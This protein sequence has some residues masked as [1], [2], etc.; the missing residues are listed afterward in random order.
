MAESSRRERTH[1][2]LIECALGL[3]ERQGFEQTTVSQI[4]SSAGVT[5]MTFFRH[6]AGKGAV[7]TADPYDPLIVAAIAAEPTDHPPLVRAI[8]GLHEAFG[9]LPD[10]AVE[11]LRRRVKIIAKS[12]T[13]RA[14]TVHH[15]ESTE[16]GVRDQLIADGATPFVA[17]ISAASLMTALTTAL[18]WWAEVGQEPLDV[19]V[20][21]ALDVLG[22]SGG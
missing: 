10:S 5:E 1:G 18:Y 3:F 17:A 7:V 15:N 4:A 6:F 16:V 11:E 13:L 12:P 19:T 9:H 20:A 8:R 2:R 22:N 21:A 14:N